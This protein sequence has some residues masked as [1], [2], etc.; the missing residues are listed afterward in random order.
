MSTCCLVIL[1]LHD[2]ALLCWRSVWEGAPDCI[3]PDGPAGPPSCRD[4]DFSLSRLAWEQGLGGTMGHLIPCKGSGEHL[5]C[6]FDLGQAPGRAEGSMQESGAGCCP[7]PAMLQR[8]GRHHE[9][10]GGA[11]GTCGAAGTARFE[12]TGCRG[13]E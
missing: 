12:C 13:L 5:G 1:M 4:Q 8:K 7:L 11:W 3:M 6:E 10:V 2:G 9:L